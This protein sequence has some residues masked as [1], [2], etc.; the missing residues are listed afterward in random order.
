MWR[1]LFLS[2][3]WLAFAAAGRAQDAVGW[4]EIRA[5]RE[6]VVA[7]RTLTL[8]AAAFTEF[9]RQLDGFAAAWRS[10][11][12]EIATVD[13]A[14][15]VRGLAPGIAEIEAA[16]PSTGVSDRLRV[17]VFPARIDLTPQNP[18][19]EVGGQM[20]LAARVLD[21]EGREIAGVRLAWRSGL[22]GIAT[23]DDR[24]VVRGVVEGVATISALVDAG[25][26]DYRFSGQ[27]Q[28]RVR[29]RPEF[30]AAR[31]AAT[32]QTAGGVSF[33][34]FPGGSNTGLSFAGSGDA[35]ASIASLSNGGRALM[36]HRNGVL[37]RLA[38]SGDY[39]EAGGGVIRNILAV[40]VNSSGDVLA[41]LSFGGCEF[42]WLLFRGERVESIV[43][44]CSS[45]VAAIGERGEVAFMGQGTRGPVLNLR[46]PDGS[47]QV[48]VGDGETLPGF[49]PAAGL[50]SFNVTSTGRVLFNACD[51]RGCFQFYWNGSRVERI[52]GPND[53][54]A[55]MVVE[56]MSAPVETSNGDIVLHA[57]NRQEQ[58]ILR[59]TAGVWT[60]LVPNR[61]GPLPNDYGICVNGLS[62]WENGV[63][64]AACGPQGLVHYRWDGDRFIRIGPVGN[65]CEFH[66]TPL[67]GIV[68]RECGGARIGR[69][70]EDAPLIAA[71]DPAPGVFA[72]SIV[73]EELKIGGTSAA[74][75][76]TPSLGGL[77]GVGARL[78]SV[79]TP[80]Q[81]M[82]G[83]GTL[84]NAP[85]AAANGAGDFAIQ[86]DTGG[87]NWRNGLY[88]WRN[89]R[90]SLLA[91]SSGAFTTDRGEPVNG[92]ACC[93]QPLAINRRNQVVAWAGLPSGQAL[94][95][96]T[97][98]SPTSRVVTKIDGPQGVGFVN[99][100]ALDDRGRVMFFTNTEGAWLYDA[101]QVSRVA[102]IGPPG[103]GVNR[104]T[105]L[106]AIAASS[107]R[108]FAIGSTNHTFAVMFE[109][110]GGTWRQLGSSNPTSFSVN[111]N[112][113]IAYITRSSSVRLI[114]RK[115]DGSEKVVATT[116]APTP[117][118]EWLLDILSAT[119]NDAGEVYYTARTASGSRDRLS[120][121]RAVPR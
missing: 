27:T 85:F 15:T 97:E 86:A 60:T 96:F 112:G 118:G 1:N 105:G 16:D 46:R 99:G 34:N 111:L 18:T 6:T 2:I 26:P 72:P 21:A 5:S 3:G 109:Y 43:T 120:L 87:A 114:L 30:T 94:L 53:A 9:G 69:V 106:N 40:S 115:A 119:I 70:G 57:S 42:P 103:P 13:E 78:Q 56:W 107:D 90:A 11:N 7:A 37:R 33:A 110:S 47:V 91:D 44:G 31:L 104:F 36:L 98:G 32:D 73:W 64:F 55:G 20:T 39:L 52:A 35:T 76:V 59:R 38:A 28:A 116:A 25:W 61:G 101:G 4:I 14:G 82:P 88:V 92:L 75:L 121:L 93:F 41:R 48:L 45:W 74:G 50:G 24:G 113:D 67:G 117:E 79:L 62:V 89:G 108:F 71:G 65:G 23:V 19:L 29:P 58:R 77:V 12:P 22:A 83:G 10:A 81:E 84:L 95:L 51:N 8:E 102:T 80:G 54:L 49:G 100:V 17:K 63:A 66:L 68:Y